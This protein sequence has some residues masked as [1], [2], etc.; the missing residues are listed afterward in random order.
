MFIF[1]RFLTT[2]FFEGITFF[3]IT[4]IA[5]FTLI[6]ASVQRVY[7]N[8]LKGMQAGRKL[9]II[10]LTVFA[11]N[12][13]FTLIFIGLFKM[14]AVGVLLS[15]LIISSFYIIYMVYDLKKIIL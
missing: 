12:I 7:Q 1:N 2:W 8:I 9:T 11:I 13:V 4:A 5:L 6:F 10:N 3:P 15:T 14:G